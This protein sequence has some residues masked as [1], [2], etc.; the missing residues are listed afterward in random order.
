MNQT[1]TFQRT[2]EQQRIPKDWIPVEEAGLKEPNREDQ[3][4]FSIRMNNEEYLYELWV[5]F[6]GLVAV[7]GEDG[8]TYLKPAK[9]VQPMMTVQG[10][11]ELI[12]FIKSQTTS[13]IALSKTKEDEMKSIY[14]SLM[15]SI[16]RELTIH[17]DK[18]GITHAQR[19]IVYSEIGSYLFHQLARA[20]KGHE[21]NNI[22]TR[23]EE[24][25]G[26]HS[27]TEQTS[28][29]KRSINPFGRSDR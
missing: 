17:K 10:A 15:A 8:R 29:K 25:K 9:H 20:V 2:D 3:D 1:T 14:R 28:R 16:R 4:T 21:A 26:E 18:Y 24:Q 5:F 7:K 19:H 13:A 23:I 11:G 12:G 6:A 27:V 22:I